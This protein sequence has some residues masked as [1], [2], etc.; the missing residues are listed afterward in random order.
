[1]HRQCVEHADVLLFD[2]LVRELGELVAP[3]LGAVTTVDEGVNVLV[4]LLVE[5]EAVLFELTFEDAYFTLGTT[6]E[7]VNQLLEVGEVHA[8]VERTQHGEGVDLLTLTD[9]HGDASGVTNFECELGSLT[10]DRNN[11][12]DERNVALGVTVRLGIDTVGTEQLR[13][14]DTLGTVVNE[15]AALGHYGH[16]THE[17]EGLLDFTGLFVAEFRLDEDW[18]LVGQSTLDTLGFGVLGGPDGL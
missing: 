12:G 5:L 2:Q 9:T 14:N 18:A 7:V 8:G 15:G 4:V 3:V 17:D 16:V 13:N 10:T 1:M 11:G 6:D